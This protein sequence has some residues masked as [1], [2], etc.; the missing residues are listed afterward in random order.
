M[1]AEFSP[2]PHLQGPTV[3]LR[4]PQETDKQDRLA[5]GRDPE[6]RRMVGGDPNTLPPLTAADVEH[7]YSQA[8]QEPH[9]WIIQA[10]GRCIGTARLHALDAENRRA[11][12]AVGIF[13][14]E[15]RGRGLGTEATHLVLAYA[16]DV[17]AL[18]RVELRVLAFNERAIACYE[19]CGFVRE[20]IEREGAWIGGQWQSDVIMSIL[21]HEYREKTGT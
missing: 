13:G 1:T 19:K 8:V 3:T 20:G 9:H 12:Y 5:Y 18:H 7:W 10:E 21:E 4:L 14:P 15:F 16:F 6:F 17:L 2:R 11:K